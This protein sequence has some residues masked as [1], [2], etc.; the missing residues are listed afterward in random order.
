MS[1]LTDQDKD[2]AE[3]WIRNLNAEIR[4]G[5]KSDY[6]KAQMKYMV[7]ILEKILKNDID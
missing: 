2:F 6:E 4:L 3:Q 1:I 5:V 7:A